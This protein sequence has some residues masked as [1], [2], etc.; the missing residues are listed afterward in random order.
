MHLPP[1]PLASQGAV[2]HEFQAQCRADT[3]TVWKP[4][5]GQ[6]NGLFRRSQ[7]FEQLA[8]VQFLAC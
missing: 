2:L 6:P 3:T 1:C 8:N 7:R 5:S 4:G